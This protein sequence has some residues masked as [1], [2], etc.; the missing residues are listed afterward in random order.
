MAFLILALISLGIGIISVLIYSFTNSDWEFGN[1]LFALVLAIGI[2][3]VS[4]FC[5]IFVSHIYYD[6]L[7]D[8]LLTEQH[9]EIESQETYLLI[10]NDDK[11]LYLT[12]GSYNFVYEDKNCIPVGVN[13]ENVN[14]VEVYTDIIGESPRVA[15][16]K[17]HIKNNFIR[18]LTFNDL[19]FVS[20]IIYLPTEDAITMRGY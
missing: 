5:I 3:I 10:S 6:D 8:K 1:I 9:F 16:R 11:F 14:H 19:I 7:A 20:Y 15:V 17:W 18:Q 4:W 13:E 2:F 12:P